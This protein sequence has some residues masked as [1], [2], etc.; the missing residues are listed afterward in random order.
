M[1]TS[2]RRTEPRSLPKQRRLTTVLIAALTVILSGALLSAPAQAAPQVKPTIVLVHGAWAD[3]SSFDAVT[4][5][6][7]DRGFKV[8]V[9]DNPLRGVAYDVAALAD[10]LDEVSGPTILVGHSYGGSLVTAV[11]TEPQVRGIVYLNAFMPERGE[12]L[13]DQI[14]GAALPEVNPLLEQLEQTGGPGLETEI[15]LPREVF[16]TAFANGLPP[17]Q[18]DAMFAA[19]RPITIAGF[20]EKMTDTPAWRVRP[21]WY[22]AGVED[23]AVPYPVQLRLAHRAGARIT[24]VHTGHA[25]MVAQP[26][27]VTGVI[28]AAADATGR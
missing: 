8:S 27:A 10:F 20:T 9:F 11:G 28:V 6:L 21:T 24:T 1:F 14:V 18:Q 5:Q 25:S 15:S 23:L 26:D 17:A 22:V 19:Q 2:R 13:V 16:N 12:S 7:I 3:A 4:E